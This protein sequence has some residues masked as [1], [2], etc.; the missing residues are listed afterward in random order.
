MLKNTQIYGD[1]FG[2]NRFPRDRFG[3]NR[4][5]AKPV[6]STTNQIINYKKKIEVILRMNRQKNI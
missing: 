4:C 6:P 1:R 5:S 2:L 3:I